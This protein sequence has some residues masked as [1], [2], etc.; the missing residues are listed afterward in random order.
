[1]QD[2]YDALDL[3]RAV[4]GGVAGITIRLNPDAVE[5]RADEFYSVTVRRLELLRNVFTLLPLLVTWAS[6][7]L[8]A[9]NYGHIAA[10][11]DVAFDRS[12]LELWQA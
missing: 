6:L 2:A 5:A 7:T 11:H 3:G 10:N 4:L 9:I 12:F 8:A 1:M